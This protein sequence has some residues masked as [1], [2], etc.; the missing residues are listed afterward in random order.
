MFVRYTKRRL[1]ERKAYTGVPSPYLGNASAEV[2]DGDRFNFDH[3][4]RV[5][6]AS[7]L[8]GRAGRKTHAQIVVADV[9]VLKEL[10]DVGHKCCGFDEMG[11]SNAGSLKCRT[12]ILADLANL[13]PHVARPDNISR[14]IACELPGNENERLC[15]GHNHVRVQDTAFERALKQ[16]LR[17]D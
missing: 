13:R 11:E 8:D 4:I 2:L 6:Q 5:R 16:R 12:D 7:H 1:R 15:F 10:V 14:L 3:Q 17:L 9:D